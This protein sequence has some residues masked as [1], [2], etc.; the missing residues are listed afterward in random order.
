MKNGENP[1]LCFCFNISN[2]F[3]IRQRGDPIELYRMFEGLNGVEVEELFTLYEPGSSTVIGHSRKIRK[4]RCRLD[5]RKYF[6]AHKVVGIWNE[7]ILFILLAVDVSLISYYNFL[8]QYITLYKG[9]FEPFDP[10]KK[11]AKRIKETDL[12]LYFSV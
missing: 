3:N 1:N 11:M 2:I 8:V 4:V 7:F 5:C 9:L 10:L 12:P 6:F